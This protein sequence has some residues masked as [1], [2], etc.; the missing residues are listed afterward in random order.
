MNAYRWSDLAVGMTHEF[1]ASFSEADV[2]DFA[3]ISGDSNPL[4]TD[5]AYAQAHGFQSMV[6]FGMLTSSLYSRLVGVYLPGQFAL[7]QGIDIHFHSPCIANE[8]LSVRGEIVYLLDAPR[9]LEIKAA[10][11]NTERKIVS[12]ATIW[13]GMHD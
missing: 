6:L 3:R 7:L 5:P 1:A 11:R 13:V 12:K 8:M 10:I 2:A 4:H 9:R